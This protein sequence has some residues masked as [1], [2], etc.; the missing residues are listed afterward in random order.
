MGLIAVGLAGF[1]Y[2]GELFK[3]SFPASGEL[4]WGVIWLPMLLVGSAGIPALGQAGTCRCSRLYLLPQPCLRIC[5]SALLRISGLR[6]CLGEA[7]N[8]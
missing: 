4:G 7:A 6:F 1:H 5:A 2:C 8:R 3:G